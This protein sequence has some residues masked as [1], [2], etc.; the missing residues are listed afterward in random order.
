MGN[1]FIGKKN[2]TKQEVDVNRVERRALRD[3][4]TK[5]QCLKLIDSMPDRVKICRKVKGGPIDH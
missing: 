5:E 1:R 3:Q 4:I 2:K